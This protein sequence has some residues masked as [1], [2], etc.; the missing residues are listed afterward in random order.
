MFVDGAAALAGDE[1]CNDGKVKCRFCDPHTAGDVDIGI[2]VGQ[3]HAKAF[4]HNCDQKIDTVIIGACRGSAWHI[5]IGVTY[6]RLHFNH[7]RT[8]AFDRAGNHGA[9]FADRLSLQHIFGWIGNFY[10][11][12]AAHFKYADL[13]GGT[14]TVFHAAQ[15]TVRSCRVAF[16]IKHRIYHMLQHTGTGDIS[17][18]GYMADDKYCDALFLRDP[19]ENACNLAHLAHAARCRVYGIVVHRLN[20]VDDRHFR[21]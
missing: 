7:K 18:F 4:F 2:T 17:L 15:D 3:L 14:K 13:V 5:E 9:R 21:L 12:L 8:R 11:S 20:R 1:C 16:K 10:Q 6:Q 19:Q